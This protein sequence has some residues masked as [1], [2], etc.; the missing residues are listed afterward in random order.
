MRGPITVDLQI[1]DPANLLR[2]CRI[3]VTTTSQDVAYC[4]TP[5]QKVGHQVQGG[6]ATTRGWSMEHKLW[7]WYRSNNACH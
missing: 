4:L 1:G 3:H 5:T 2:L 7:A 6:K